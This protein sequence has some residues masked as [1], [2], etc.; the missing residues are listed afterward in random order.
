M[1]ILRWDVSTS[2]T[3]KLES[4]TVKKKEKV[5]LMKREMSKLL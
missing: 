3:L 1:E 5:L 4:N 2:S